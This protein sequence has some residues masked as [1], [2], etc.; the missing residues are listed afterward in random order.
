[1]K[2]GPTRRLDPMDRIR[3]LGDA[4]VPFVFDAHAIIY[5]DDAPALERALHLQFDPVRVNAQN[6]RKGGIT[7]EVQHRV[8]HIHS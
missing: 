2:I 3:E 7:N 8:F 1:V 4:S 6:Y 5:S